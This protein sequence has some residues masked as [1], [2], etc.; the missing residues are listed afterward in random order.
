MTQSRQSPNFA[1]KHDRRAA[2]IDEQL[3]R[4]QIA[5]LAH[6]DLLTGLTNRHRFHEELGIALNRVERGDQFGLL[7]LDIDRFS[8]INDTLGLAA[9]DKLLQAVGQRLKGSLRKTDVVARMGS[10]EF[11]VIQVLAK[12]PEGATALAARLIEDLSKPHEVDG[13]QVLVGTSIGIALA[14]AD[15][16]DGDVLLRNANLALSRAKSEGRGAF[17]LFEE[18]MDRKMQ[19]R[20]RLEIDLQEAVVRDQF[21][22]HYQPV[23]DATTRAV[24]GFEALLRWRHPQ[25]GLVSPLDF[26]AVAEDI[27]LMGTIGAWVLKQ[28]CIEAMHWP[29]GLRVAINVSPAQFRARWLELDVMAALDA[30]GLPADR[31]ELEITESVLLETAGSTVGMLNRLRELGIR[32]A[33]D[34]FGTGYSS[35]SYL[36]SIPFDKIKLDRSFVSNLGQSRSALTIIQAVVGLAKGLGMSTTAEGVETEEQLRRLQA[37]G[38]TEV[39]GYLFSKPVPAGEVQDL[40]R[41]LGS[42]SVHAG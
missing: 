28:G 36:L 20:R 38:C 39:Q 3:L 27:S 7:C 40:L 6:H 31:L 26:L 35:I 5:H 42:R 30:S 18:G 9:G 34:D 8:Q 12:Q 25:R 11:A 23:I 10:D 1:G 24:T 41:R 33:M 16:T 17:R 14:P 19:A 21:E 29:A 22:L 4:Q 37:E 32:V 15:G 13:H 2:G